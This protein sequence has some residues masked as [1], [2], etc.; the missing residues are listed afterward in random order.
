MGLSSRFCCS[1]RCSARGNVVSRG[2][3][4][5]ADSSRSGIAALDPRD[6][7]SS[8]HGDRLRFRRSTSARCFVARSESRRRCGAGTRGAAEHTATRRLSA[9]A[10][11]C[12]MF[13]VHAGAV[14]SSFW[15]VGVSFPVFAD[16]HPDVG[17]AGA[18]YAAGNPASSATSDI[19]RRS[20]S[21]LEGVSPVALRPT[22]C[23][24]SASATTLST[25]PG[26][27]LSIAAAIS[28]SRLTPPSAPKSR[29]RS[30]VWRPAS[31]RSCCIRRRTSASLH[32][33]HPTQGAAAD[34]AADDRGGAT[35]L[36]KRCLVRTRRSTST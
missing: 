9:P 11:T 32:R 12:D 8:L 6:S 17:A 16:P 2:A 24:T 36:I 35:A 34:S 29:S 33:R 19:A 26:E 21:S 3:R 1:A 27:R 30:R 23:T 28:R 25:T 14:W 31:A 18:H 20:T 4:R 15:S 10:S 5:R 7:R 13:R 22:F